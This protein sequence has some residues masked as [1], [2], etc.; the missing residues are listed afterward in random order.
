AANK[1]DSLRNECQVQGQL[2]A[3]QKLEI[4]TLESVLLQMKEDAQQLGLQQA[5]QLAV[6]ENEKLILQQQVLQ[7][8]KEKDDFNSLKDSIQL[9][10][11]QL[12]TQ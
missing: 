10:Q 1:I 12:T 5:A 3:N 9:L 4:K 7:Q 8:V 11:K 6:L 2:A